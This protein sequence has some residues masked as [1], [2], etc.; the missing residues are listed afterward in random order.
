[1]KLTAN[2]SFLIGLFLLLRATAV[3]AQGDHNK[4]F[5]GRR[6]R[7]DITFEGNADECS[8]TGI[9]FAKEPLMGGAPESLI[10]T[11]RYGEM[12]VEARDSVS[13]KLI[14]SR[15]FSTLFQEWQT[16]DRA[17]ENTRKF[18]EIQA[19]PFP[20]NTL[21]IDL[22]QRKGIH[23][24]PLNTTYFNPS[25]TA[26]RNSMPP[27]EVETNLFR[28][29]ADSLYAMNLV[30]LSE[31]YTPEE[32]TQFYEHVDALVTS[33]LQ[34]E[35]YAELKDYLNVYTVYLPSRESGAD[36][37]SN[38]RIVATALDCSFNTFGSE[39]YLTSS[40]PQKIFDLAS[41]TPWDQLIVLVNTEK[42]GGG[43]IYNSCTFVSAGSEHAGFL[44][45]HEFAHAFAALAD[46]Y[47][48]SS[49]A[50]SDYFDLNTEPYQPNITT[51][52]D[53]SHKWANLIHDTVPVPTPDT[54][55][56]DGV[57][58]VYE[59]AGY[60]AKG[61]YRPCRTCIMKSRS[62]KYF[63]PVCRKSIAEMLRFRAGVPLK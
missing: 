17:K 28:S 21:R 11:F 27:K 9:L 2:S 8:V 57:V 56:Y 23:F 43:A 35:P 18:T 63:C 62:T 40:R 61:I 30:F 52:V 53:F 31:G 29:A 10:D 14:F 13:G 16:T 42:Y 45:L 6:L 39:R 20:G 60:S 4:W 1:M 59:G 47:Y 19:I 37:P 24:V 50:Y 7:L 22:L 15:G 25:F 5:T 38:N 49:V 55:L 44:L 34:T 32:Q 46:E 48:T 12:I 54:S 3:F 58:G 41:G 33:M 36:D 26:Y 51:L